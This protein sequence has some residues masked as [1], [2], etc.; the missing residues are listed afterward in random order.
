[1][2]RPCGVLHRAACRLPGRQRRDV[3]TPRAA[4]A[5]VNIE[6]DDP[7]ADAVAD[8]LRARK[9]AANADAAVDDEDVP[10]VKRPPEWTKLL[11]ITLTT[12]LVGVV[13]LFVCKRALSPSTHVGRALLFRG[14]PR[15]N[16]NASV[17]RADM[18]GGHTRRSEASPAIH[19]RCF[20]TLYSRQ[21]RSREIA[22][23][24]S[25]H[26]HLIIDRTIGLGTARARCNTAAQS[27]VLCRRAPGVGT[28]VLPVVVHPLAPEPARCQQ[29]QRARALPRPPIRAWRDRPRLPVGVHRPKCAAAPAPALCPRT[30]RRRVACLTQTGRRENPAAYAAHTS[31][32]RSRRHDRVCAVVCTRHGGAAGAVAARNACARGISRRR[33]ARALRARVPQSAARDA[34]G[35]RRVGGQVR[36]RSLR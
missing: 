1:M 12:G 27:H 3:R 9:G 7:H 8:S 13:E 26:W 24:R 16:S 21:H 28:R 34:K 4:T 20:Q 11:A 2:L 31:L 36:L 29:L 25:R 5:S 14:L 10:E 33:G 22:W 18:W 17:L 35:E 6:A 32:A 19:A 23:C 15:A 30:L